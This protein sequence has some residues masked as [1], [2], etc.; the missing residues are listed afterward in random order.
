MVHLC[1][2]TKWFLLDKDP[3]YVPNTGLRQ[4]FSISQCISEELAVLIP[5]DKA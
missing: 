5:N 4:I 1:L 3:L 2:P